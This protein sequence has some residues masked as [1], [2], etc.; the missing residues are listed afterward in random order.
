MG[1]KIDKLMES[2]SAALAEVDTRELEREKETI[3]AHEDINGLDGVPEVGIIAS[4]TRAF[5][6][7]EDI[8]ASQEDIEGLDEKLDMAKK[9][10]LK[11]L[12]PV[13]SLKEAVNRKKVVDELRASMEDYGEVIEVNKELI[14]STV[15]ESRL[16]DSVVAM[17]DY[18]TVDVK[19]SIFNTIAFNAFNSTQEP[20]DSVVELFFPTVNIDPD[21]AQS[22]VEVDV[23]HFVKPSKRLPNGN[24]IDYK[25]APYIKSLENLQEFVIDGNR[26]Y[27][28]LRIDGEYV[29]TD[30]LLNVPGVSKTVEKIDGTEVVTAPIKAGVKVDILGISQDNTLIAKGLMDEL[31]TIDP[32]LNVTALYFKLTGKDKDGNDVTEYYRKDI[33]G[34]PLA[35]VPTNTGSVYDMLLNENR[36]LKFTAP[37]I[38]VEGKKTQI[39]ALADLTDGYYIR[40]KTNV[41]GDANIDLGYVNVNE[42]EHE[43][44]GI[45][46]AN[47]NRL[48]DADYQDA[49]DVLRN[50]ELVGY[51]L[52]AY[53]NNDTAVYEGKRLNMSKYV[54]VYNIPNRVK[55]SEKTPP[56]QL[57]SVK[58]P[59]GL[60]SLVN[61]SKQVLTAHGY[62]TLFN[63]INS[64]D[65]VDNDV[66][67][68]GVANFM[69]D[70]FKETYELD[71]VKLV[72]SLKSSERENDI[73]A[74]L[75]LYIKNIAWRMYN[76]SNY[77]FAFE[78]YYP[79]Q[80]PTVIIG[81]SIRIGQFL[82]S[83]EDDA[84]RYVVK[85]SK[86]D[87]MKDKIIL[88]F[89]I[90][91]NSRNQVA[92]PL[93]F[94]VC[95]RR[96]DLV[97]TFQVR[98][99]KKKFDESVVI[100]GFKHQPLLPIISVVNVSRLAE[101][102]KS[103]PVYTQEVTQ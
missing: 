99:S 79:G 65:H 6:E 50:A 32:Y 28:I 27:P 36:V 31:N 61:Y 67:N 88:S 20:Q 12:D 72:N 18:S 59:R 76:E 41:K 66:T 77:K 9:L 37:F 19:K 38:T 75:Q 16:I 8:T 22:Y 57:G 73:Q 52:E 42:F 54:F 70:K 40:Y 26:L 93:N 101:A 87:I 30:K 74:A 100:L 92:N 95:F 21:V 71:V 64:L 53:G 103:I 89:G 58:H 49:L 83:F 13:K 43:V 47:G 4:V 69:V 33:V 81:T 23:V 29:N 35:F 39:K 78:E 94:G 56:F 10:V 11:A 55:I 98:E 5:S 97:L 48:P 82:T 46:D 1:I 2:L 102:V 45:Y 14:P 7:A 34:I 15:N 68:F 3:V 60:Y 84:F 17:E 91:D 85:T 90:M 96:P 63:F 24:P 80:K 51:D 86:Y 62:T 44:L 25:G